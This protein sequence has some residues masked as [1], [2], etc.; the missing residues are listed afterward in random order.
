MLG[1]RL[2][3]NVIS[4]LNDIRRGIFGV[5]GESIKWCLLPLLF[6]TNFIASFLFGVSC[7]NDFSINIFYVILFKGT[8]QSCPV[9]DF[10]SNH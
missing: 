4:N 8:N 9:L 10:E 5:E 7:L 1:S 3:L 6:F 2:A